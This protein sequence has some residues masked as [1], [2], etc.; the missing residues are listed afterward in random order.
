ML[1]CAT[2]SCAVQRAAQHSETWTGGCEEDVR[3]DGASSGSCSSR[4]KVDGVKR[5][6]VWKH[7]EATEKPREY[8]AVR[9]GGNRVGRRT[10][11]VSNDGASGGSCLSRLKDEGLDVVD[12]KQWCRSDTVRVVEKV[13]WT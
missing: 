9:N 5:R 10:E 8:A 2:C 13:V 6:A 7:E 11:D 1:V 4:Q 12:K 3:N